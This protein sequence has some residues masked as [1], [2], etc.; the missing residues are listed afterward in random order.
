MV[1]A[2]VA[3]RSWGSVLRRLRTICTNIANVAVLSAE[4]DAPVVMG[5]PRGRAGAQKMPL[6][7]EKAPV[8]VARLP[9]P[10]HRYPTPS[11]A[12]LS[13]FSF[14]TKTTPLTLP[15]S[16]SVFPGPK[17]SSRAPKDRRGSPPSFQPSLDP[18]GER[19]PTPISSPAQ[20]VHFQN[21]PQGPRPGAG[22]HMH[23]RFF[24]KSLK[25]K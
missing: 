14:S 12:I 17:K 8:P 20:N 18:S 9:A 6:T 3:G 11:R 25:V 15:R 16:R 24:F 22:R 23:G 5:L 2:L 13:R 7:V 10:A 19:Y 4:T 1:G 21:R